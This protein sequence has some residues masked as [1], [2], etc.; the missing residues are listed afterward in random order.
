MNFHVEGNGGKHQAKNGKYYFQVDAGP[1]PMSFEDYMKRVFA[2]VGLRS[3]SIKA[4]DNFIE[5]PFFYDMVENAKNTAT[6][7]DAVQHPKGQKIKVTV[8]VSASVVKDLRRFGINL[9][10]NNKGIAIFHGYAPTYEQ[11]VKKFQNFTPAPEKPVSQWTTIEKLDSVIRRAALL[12]PEEVGNELL[13]L[14]EPWALV[15]MVV[16]LLAWM[17]GH[18]FAVSE[19]IDVLLVLGGLALGFAAYQAGGHLASFGIGCVNGRTE[20]DLDESAKHLAE[21]VALVGVQLVMTLLLAKAPKFFRDRSGIKLSQLPNTE[22]PMGEWFYK[23]KIKAVDSFS[24]SGVLGNTTV[25]GDIEYLSSL[26][27][28]L[29]AE[30]ILHERVHS[31]LTP[32]LYPLRNLRVVMTING[33]NKSFLLNYLEEALAETVAQ[34]GTYGLKNALVGIKFPIRENYVTLTQMGTEAAGIF[35]GPVNAGG[36]YYRVYLNFAGQKSDETQTK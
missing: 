24:K 31:F 30:T 14:V 15:A 4:F 3:E 7:A 16:V 22:R 17:I 5:Q 28:D 20:K 2:G 6:V 19:I 32:K 29:K 25:Y 11:K 10:V 33:Y 26:T 12:L 21:A 35:I 8:G 1:N 23:P 27:G 36:I 18:F 9:L 34:V 13:K